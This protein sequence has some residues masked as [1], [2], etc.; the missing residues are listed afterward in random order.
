MRISPLASALIL[1]SIALPAFAQNDGNSPAPS[2]Q[3]PQAQ[4]QTQGDRP[5]PGAGQGRGNWRQ[6]LGQ[7]GAQG[8]NDKR[9]ERRAKMLARFDLNHDGQLDDNEKAQMK[10]FI[11]QKRQAKMAKQGGQSLQGATQ[12]GIPPQG[13]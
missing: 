9:Q 4:T 3:E 8:S 5:G 13:Q 12:Q 6:R 2:G 1:L 7:G 11:Q 10:Q